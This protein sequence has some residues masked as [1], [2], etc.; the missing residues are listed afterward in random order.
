MKKILLTILSVI[1][2]FVS[3][4]KIN[5]ITVRMPS[6]DTEVVFNVSNGIATKAIVD[7]TVMLDHFG[8][9]GYVV[10]GNFAPNGGY[11]MKNGEYDENGDAVSGPYYW[12]KSD[13]YTGIDFIFTAYSQFES[14]PT[15][16][17]DT[18]KLV[19][20]TLKQALIDNEDDFDDI[21]W[22]QTKYN[23]HQNSLSDH[24]RV[25]LNL[26]GEPSAL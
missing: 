25:V 23:Y 9:Y 13:N 8:I 14:V 24:E 19:V 18:L 3:C 10:P 15:W 11:L 12:P 4:A 21:L 26:V 16:E 2:I 20:P 5:D 22:A 1:L 6:Q 7:T 17:N